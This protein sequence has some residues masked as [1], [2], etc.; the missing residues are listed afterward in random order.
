[1]SNTDTESDRKTHCELFSFVLNIFWICRAYAK[2][3]LQL[4]AYL[5]FRLVRAGRCVRV[6]R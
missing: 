4:F 2:N 6:Q 5:R 1:M 3:G